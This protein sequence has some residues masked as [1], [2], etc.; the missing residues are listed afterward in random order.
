M[1]EFLITINYAVVQ[2]LQLWR[3]KFAIYDVFIYGEREAV[4]FVSSVVFAIIIRVHKVGGPRNRRRVVEGER[5]GE[6]ND[7]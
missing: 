5:E 7:G 4:S 1:E 6:K 2:V 3:F